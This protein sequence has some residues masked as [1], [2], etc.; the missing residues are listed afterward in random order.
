[1]SGDGDPGD[2]DLETR[3]GHRFGDASLLRLAL[4][5]RSVSGLKVSGRRGAVR[6]GVGSNERLEFIGDRVLGLAVAEWLLERFPDEQEGEL[7]S[8]HAHLVS[9]EA[10]ARVA[11]TLGL[12]R[13]L[14]LAPDALRAGVG[15]LSNV[16]AD[17]AEAILGALYLDGGIAPARAVVRRF[18]ADEMA[19]DREPPKDAKT[20]LQEWLLARARPLPEYVETGRA[21]PSHAPVFRIEARAGQ[22]VGTG[23]AASKRVA[24]RIAAASLLQVLQDDA[25]ARRRTR[26]ETQA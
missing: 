7:G 12:E 16:L 6:R 1:M 18:W 26:K 19:R 3:L 8:R 15:G 4:T 20:A 23:E 24:E 22:R 21:G 25:A 2:A 13:E 10:L 9:R 14:A 17:A 5:H 11:V